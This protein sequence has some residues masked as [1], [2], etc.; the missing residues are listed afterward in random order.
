MLIQVLICFV[1]SPPRPAGTYSQHGGASDEH[2]KRERS[3]AR[4]EGA[5][6]RGGHPHVREEQ[7]PSFPLA[8]A[9][10]LEV[11]VPAA[12]ALAVVVTGLCGVV[13]TT[14]PWPGSNN[15]DAYN[16]SPSL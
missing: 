13:T 16:L 7:P 15:G 11:A 8:L 1:G 5:D 9:F 6:Q 3:E 14:A 4:R 2:H 10:P 12:L